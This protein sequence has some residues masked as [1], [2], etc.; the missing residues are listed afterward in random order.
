M[1]DDAPVAE[2]ERIGNSNAEVQIPRGYWMVSW[3]KE[4]FG[5]PETI[6]DRLVDTTPVGSMGPVMQPYWSPG[7]T[8]PEAKGAI[9][10]FGDVHSRAHVY[11]AI[12]EGL[13]FALRDG[14]ERIERRGRV[15]ITGLPA[16]RPHVYE[17]SG[18]GA[19]IDAAVGLR[20]YPDFPSAVRTITRAPRVF[21]PRPSARG[22]YDDLYERVY[23]KMYERLK[24]LYEAIREITG[25]PASF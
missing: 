2:R 20:M 21:E 24:P 16:A 6:L 19:A 14:K 12:L 13:A 9:V 15:Q 23:L 4:Q 18:L 25:Y 17:T 11:R 1:L 10:G 7:I 5:L 3:F 22:I 8:M